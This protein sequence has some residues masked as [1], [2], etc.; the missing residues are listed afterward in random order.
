MGFGIDDIAKGILTYVFGTTRETAKM[1]VKDNLMKA[2][3][4]IGIALIPSEYLNIDIEGEEFREFRLTILT[5]AFTKAYLEIDKETYAEK[6]DNLEIKE[7]K[8]FTKTL[9]RLGKLA[10]K[11][12]PV[13]ED[14]NNPVLSD[15]LLQVKNLQSLI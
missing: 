6:M 3:S 8:S 12:L 2:I 10:R 13:N 15:Q 5:E 1:T 9:R 7:M 14:K 11:G 4:K